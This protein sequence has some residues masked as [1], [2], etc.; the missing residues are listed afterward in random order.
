MVKLIF[1]WCRRLLILSSQQTHTQIL[2]F[3]SIFICL[4]VLTHRNY[5]SRFA[6]L[7]NINGIRIKNPVKVDG[8]LIFCLLFPRSPNHNEFQKFPRNFPSIFVCLLFLL[9]PYLIRV[10][11]MCDIKSIVFLSFHSLSPMCAR[12]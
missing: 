11:V 6:F 1:L 5:S 3:F 4:F 8:K 7:F 10:M 2:I 12:V 9:T